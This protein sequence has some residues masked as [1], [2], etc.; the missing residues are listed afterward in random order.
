[1]SMKALWLFLLACWP[2]AVWAQ[3][4]PSKYL[5]A[6][7]QKAFNKK[8]S[9]ASDLEW[10]RNGELYE[11]GFQIKQVDHKALFDENG[12]LLVYKKDIQITELPTAVLQT[13]RT[14]YEKFKIDE[15][16]K[17]ERKGKVYYQVELDGE[18]NDQK[19]IFNK[20]GKEDNSETYW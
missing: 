2:F 7:V 11:A 14:R 4:I 9:G 6:A 18:P 15:A 8:F 17:V 3:E 19:L 10:E 5:P 12:D 20:A 1:M 16:E 13:I